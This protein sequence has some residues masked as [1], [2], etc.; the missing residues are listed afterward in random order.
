MNENSA[1]RE[2]HE[3]D[4][5]VFRFA[6]A[7]S[8][9]LIDDIQVHWLV[10]MV[11]GDTLRGKRILPIGKD[12]KP[13]YPGTLHLNGS[14]ILTICPDGAKEPINLLTP[15][16]SE[17]IGTITEWPPRGTKLRLQK[18]VPYYLADKFDESGNLK[19]DPGPPI[20]VVKDNQAEL[21]HENSIFLTTVPKIVQ[22]SYVGANGE[23]W[24]DGDV[25]GV[26]LEWESTEGT[27]GLEAPVHSYSIYR[28]ESPEDVDAWEWVTSVR[29]GTHTYTDDAV[30]GSADVEYLV[31]HGTR[32]NFSYV[33]EG[34]F[35]VPTVVKAV[36]SASEKKARNGGAG[37]RWREHATPDSLMTPIHDKMSRAPAALRSS[38]VVHDLRKTKA[39]DLSTLGIMLSV[40]VEFQGET[41]VLRSGACG[42]GCRTV[43]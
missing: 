5:V 16:G 33:Y 40:T 2:H 14:M 4:V 37:R 15:E 43:T 23:S 28:N 35:G 12:G 39:E 9:R 1:Q 10:R 29:A 26:R 24:K 8:A 7:G 17:L 36:R 19:A 25:A 34:L 21:Q 42:S 11:E 20:L 13:T 31:I 3:S 38:G 30:D 18:D 6:K 22:A 27:P 41:L 32:F